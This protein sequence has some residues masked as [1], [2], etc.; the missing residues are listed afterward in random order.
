[1]KVAGAV[2]LVTGGNRGL[3][4][5]YVQALLQAGTAKVYAAVRDPNAVVEP[6]STAVHLDITD[7]QAVA[8]AVKT[9]GDATLLINNAGT[10]HRSPFLSAQSMDAARSEMETNYFG[11]LAMC[12]AFAAIL[13]RNGGGALVNMLS[14]VS[15][16][17]YPPSG[18]QCAAKAAQ[19]SL[20]NGI[21]IELRAQNTLVVGVFAGFIDTDMSRGIDVP[22]SAPLAIA[23][24]VIDG[25]EAGEEEILADDRSV[26]VREAISRSPMA[27]YEDMQRIWD[28]AHR[29][30]ALI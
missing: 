9:C 3:G 12:R 10:L 26:A 6:G 21:R 7:P 16:F 19:L 2:A 23:R 17:T 22:K 5:A 30:E 28:A 27:I 15:W 14:V 4:R 18:S 29:A 1:V 20:T 8:A 25:I 11:T 24:R 13:G